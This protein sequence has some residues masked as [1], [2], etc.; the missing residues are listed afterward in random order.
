MAAVNAAAGRGGA[1]APPSRP[2]DPAEPGQDAPVSPGPTGGGWSLVA[3]IANE[4]V[5]PP[6]GLPDRDALAT[7]CAVSTLWHPSLLALADL[8]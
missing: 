3:L 1:A 5:E 8:R 7:W 4:G 6:A 2:C